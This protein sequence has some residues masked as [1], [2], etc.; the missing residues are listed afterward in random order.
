METTVNPTN[1]RKNLF[2]LIKDANR[3]SKPVIIAGAN[4]DKSAVLMSKRDYDAQQETME[5][6]L[7]GQL[8]DAIDRKNDKS[9]SLSQMMKDIDNE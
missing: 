1:A 7:N 9:V 3:D 8:K 5:L 2:E 4:D 6:L